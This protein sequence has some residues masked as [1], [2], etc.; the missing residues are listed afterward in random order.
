[1]KTAVINVKIDEKVK[2]KAQSLAEELGFSLS[3][4]VNAY[5]K[6]FIE[7]K[8]V[9][10]TRNEKPSVYLRQAMKEAEEEKK[11]GDYYSS[12]EDPKDALKFLDNAKKWKGGKV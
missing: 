1:M 5:L 12:F 8:T 9:Y 7:E 10:F 4:L 3:S 11:G 6:N 2:K